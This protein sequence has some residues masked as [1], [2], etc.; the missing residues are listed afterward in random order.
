AWRL[1]GL[2]GTARAETTPVQV[3]ATQEAPR[4]EVA[5]EDDLHLV[6]ARGDDVLLA[7]EP[8]QRERLEPTA[9]AQHI[10]RIEKCALAGEIDSGYLVDRRVMRTM[11][12]GIFHKVTDDHPLRWG[13][14]RRHRAGE[15][16]R[17]RAKLPQQG[18]PPPLVGRAFDVHRDHVALRRGGDRRAPQ[19]QDR[20]LPAT[21][22]Q[23]PACGVERRGIGQ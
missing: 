12:L 21:A 13:P 1:P 2:L 18:A 3:A 14:P 7:R 19:A 10:V 8:P 20:R 22:V 6:A 9:L 11:K 5:P 4:L 23:L 15:H 17:A 16:A